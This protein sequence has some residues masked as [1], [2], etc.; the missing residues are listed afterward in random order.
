MIMAVENTKT[1][2]L[3]EN[4]SRGQIV[5]SKEVDK[6]LLDGRCNHQP[7]MQKCEKSE[8]KVK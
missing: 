8:E 1:T 2:A 6:Q 3:G 4:E 7:P 5:E